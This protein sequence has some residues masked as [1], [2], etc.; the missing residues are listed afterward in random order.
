MFGLK[1]RR[2]ELG[3]PGPFPGSATAE[4]KITWS[5]CLA[6]FSNQDLFCINILITEAYYIFT[7]LA[8]SMSLASGMHV[9]L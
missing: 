8:T 4:E 3:P 7:C 2:G 9:Y 6:D 1:I 5:S